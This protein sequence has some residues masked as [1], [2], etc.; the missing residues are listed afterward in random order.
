MSVKPYFQSKNTNDVKPDKLETSAKP[1]EL[2]APAKSDK[3]EVYTK[4][5]KL[6]APLLTLK[7]FQ[8]PTKPAKPAIKY[9]RGRPCKN[10]VMENYLTSIV[11]S[12]KQSLPAD[13]L[14]LIQ[15]TPFMDLQHKEI[16]KLL[17]KGVFAV[18]TEKDIL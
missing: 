11:I 4:L 7:V 12:I 10:P 13:I 2:K 9:G 3:L 16:N 15:D 14:V 18:I 17:K 8:K 6:K 1:N 5:D